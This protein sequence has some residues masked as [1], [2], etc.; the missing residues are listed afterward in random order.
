MTFLKILQRLYKWKIRGF[1]QPMMSITLIL[2]AYRL[3]GWKPIMVVGI[4]I[5]SPDEPFV[6]HLLLFWI[7]AKIF[8]KNY[9]NDG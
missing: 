4:G 3:Y 2:S 9:A 6:G 5:H 7:F 8:L 1:I